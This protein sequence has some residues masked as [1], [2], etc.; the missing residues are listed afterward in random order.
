VGLHPCPETKAGAFGNDEDRPAGPLMSDI[1]GIFTPWDLAL[2]A[3]VAGSPGLVIGAI[4]GALA[5]PTRR[6][7]GAGLGALAGFAVCLGAVILWI[8]AIK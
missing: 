6:L 7:T 4:A 5:A 8:V 1:G 3:F 2:M